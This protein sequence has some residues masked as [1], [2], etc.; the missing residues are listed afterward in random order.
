MEYANRLADLA[1]TA[2]DAVAK[3]RTYRAVHALRQIYGFSQEEKMQITRHWLKQGCSTY[4][5]LVAETGFPKPEISEIVRAMVEA[6]QATLVEMSIG[7]AAG[8]KGVFISV[9]KSQ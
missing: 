6:G 2:P 9:A 3:N 1:K 7:G 4:D 8:R 5:D